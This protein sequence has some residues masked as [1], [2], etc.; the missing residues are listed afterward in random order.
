M[1]GMQYIQHRVIDGTYQAVMYWKVMNGVV[2]I[3]EGE[4]WKETAVPVKFVKDF[5]PVR[6]TPTKDNKEPEA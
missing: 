6:S 3:K 2:Y 5:A 4:A 1:E